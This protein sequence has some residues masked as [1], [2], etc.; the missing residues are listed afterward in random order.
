MH[1][2]FTASIAIGPAIPPNAA[3][4]GPSGLHPAQDDDGGRAGHSAEQ[5][6]HKV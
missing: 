5:D 3:C 1:L 4:A 6:I 2:S